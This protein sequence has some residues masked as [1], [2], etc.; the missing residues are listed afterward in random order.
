VPLATHWRLIKGVWYLELERPDASALKSFLAG[1]SPPVKPVP[2]PPAIPAELKFETT[3]VG[4]EYVH[5][6]EV[7]TARF[8]FTNIS[9][10][11]VSVEIP[12]LGSNCLRLKTPQKT[13][14]PGESGVLEF[15]FDPSSFQF[16]VEQA[17]SMGVTL[18][19]L[20]GGAQARLT[21]AA[22]LLP[23]NEPPPK[24]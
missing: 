1:T 21:I 2:R 6:G 24:H 10:H 18:K 15:E 19:T 9:N 12:D 16:N 23:D 3:W 8:P 7:K 5:R 22:V 13:F 14:K 11:D 17:L 4:L 20:P